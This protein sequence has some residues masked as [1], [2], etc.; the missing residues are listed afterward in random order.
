ML[1]PGNACGWE[2]LDDVVD[3][4]DSGDAYVNVH[5]EGF[6][7]G[8]LRGQISERDGKKQKKKMMKRMDMD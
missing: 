4:L 1:G 2:D 5:T 8:E 6:P 7:S 3:A